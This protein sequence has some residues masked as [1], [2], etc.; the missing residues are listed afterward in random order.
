MKKEIKERNSESQTLLLEP[1]IASCAGSLNTQDSVPS[2]HK[3]DIPT[4]KYLSGKV[5]L[6]EA[7]LWLYG[8]LEKP[9]VDDER[10]MMT[11]EN[12][13]HSSEEDDSG[14]SRSWT[15]HDGIVEL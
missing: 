13:N 15:E 9:N 11:M 1:F 10:T 3:C 14:S 7:I 6:A 4:Q 12:H 5:G 2:P 8:P